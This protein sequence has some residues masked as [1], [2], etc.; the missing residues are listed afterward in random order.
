MNLGGGAR[1][2]RGM[3]L[4]TYSTLV[5][6]ERAA[7]NRKPAAAAILSRSSVC[8]SASVNCLSARYGFGGTSLD[9]KSSFH[10]FSGVNL[11]IVFVGK[12]SI[13][14]F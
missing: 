13:F 14:T 2:R 9:Q 6:V 7:K 3:T 1:N 12:A 4:D 10:A 5:P 8:G 11:G